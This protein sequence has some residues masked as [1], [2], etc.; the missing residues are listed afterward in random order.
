M[1]SYRQNIYHIVFRTKESKRVIT[2]EKSEM[3][4]AYIAA[5]IRNKNS[6]LYS[7]NGTEN[8]LHILT[9][10]HPSIALADFMREIKAS[11]SIWVSES[12]LFPAFNGWAEGYGSFT[13]SYRN[14]ENL[15]A[16]IKNQA[17]HHKKKSFE[18]EYRNLIIESGITI[19]DRYFP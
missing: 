14:L 7:I 10:I 6:H 18:E 17:I 9:D 15:I 5:I 1:T 13:C 8:H 11:S 19:D 12:G 4:Y 16:Y 2:R 3:L